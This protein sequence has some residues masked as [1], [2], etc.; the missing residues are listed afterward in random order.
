MAYTSI[1]PL[2]LLYT[3]SGRFD[4]GGGDGP[5]GFGF[6]RLVSRW[7]GSGPARDDGVCLSAS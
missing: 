6:L 3:P 5:A 1:D 2:L 7:E 4:R